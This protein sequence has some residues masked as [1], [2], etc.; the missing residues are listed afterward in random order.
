MRPLLKLVNNYSLDNGITI[1]S[2]KITL[3][4]QSVIL[5]TSDLSENTDYTISVAGVSDVAITPNAI[6]D[7]IK[8]TFTHTSFLLNTIGA[9]D[10]DEGEG[11]TLGDLSGNNNDATLMNG[12]GYGE[13]KTGNGLL[14]DG[15]DDYAEVPTS[16][17]LDISGEQVSI[18]IWAKM[19]YLPNELPGAFGPMYD[20]ETDNYVIYEDKG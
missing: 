18:S 15:V 13:G 11:T 17:S 9:W 2:A 5:S 1:N 7:T 8:K 20:S 10:S 16:T 12:L 19:G 4:S 14:Y 3:D 6:T